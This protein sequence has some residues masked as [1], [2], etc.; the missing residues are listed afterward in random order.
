MSKKMTAKEKRLRAETRKRLR[1][2]GILPPKKSPL[3]RKK[4][5]A[6]VL[7]DKAKSSSLYDLYLNHVPNAISCMIAGHDIIGVTPE[8]VGVFKVLRIALDE[9]AF[10]NGLK[11][12]AEA[13]TPTR[14]FLKKLSPRSSSYRPKAQPRE[15]RGHLKWRGAHRLKGGQA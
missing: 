12:K 11:K 9:Q 15:S 7:E 14:S 8:M 3:N 4:F 2:D 6:Q 1:A 5:A 10:L 13:A